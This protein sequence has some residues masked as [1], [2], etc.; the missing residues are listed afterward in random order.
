M[1]AN[2]TTLLRQLHRL[3]SPLPTAP[4]GDAILL[5]RF[6]RRRDEEAFAALVRRHGPMVLRVCRR[7]L[8]DADAAAD[9]CQAV[10]CVLA[11][12][13]AAIHSPE[14]LP[15]WLHGVAC[16]VARKARAADARRRGREAPTAELDPP[17]PH[18]DPLA[19]LSARDLL[20]T[21]D[22]EV[23]RLPEAHRLPVILCCLEGHTR[24]EAARLLGWSPGAVKGRLERGRARL[25]ARLVRRGLAL[26]A[27]L[28]AVEVARGAATL[29]PRLVCSAV[30][31]G[32]AF[33]ARNGGVSEQVALLAEAGLPAIGLARGKWV[34]A[35]LLA[36]SAVAAGAGM[37]AHQ[38]LA[39]K[40]P[41]LAAEG[42]AEPETAPAART[43]RYGDP[44]PPGALARLG[45]VRFRHPGQI[46]AFALSPDGKTVATGGYPGEVRLWE[47]ATGKPTGSLRLQDGHVLAL[48]FTPDGSA[49]AAVGSVSAD[50]N[51]AG[52]TVLFDLGT[53][54]PR[55]TLEHRHWARCLAFS[56]DGTTL[57]VGCDR[58]E[59]GTW[60]VASG[61]ERP[62]LPGEFGPGFA[63]VAFSPDGRLLA[64]GGYDKA[65]RLWDWRAGHEVG[66]LDAGS[67]VRSL[68]FASGGKT[69]LA[70]Q[71][72]PHFVQLWDVASR[73]VLRE[74][75]GHKGWTGGLLPG[76]SYAVALA[77][78]G[79]T[80]ASGGDDATVLL[81]DAGTAE[82][83]GRHQDQAG[84]VNGVAF[85]PDGKTLLTGGTIGR[86]RLFDVAG[87]KE[88]P[89]FDE[90]TGGLADMALSPD[91]KLLAT[92]SADR[93]ICLWDL[94]A[95]RTVRVLRGHRDGVYSVL[96]SPD[97]RSLVSGGGDGTVRV[98]DVA[99]GEQRQLTDAH[100]WYSRAAFA[101]D[102]KL[103]ASAG[104]DSKV[105]LWEPT[106]GREL[107]QL[108]GHMGY[109]V[110]LDISSDGKWLA[111]T[112][113]SYSGNDRS[114][115]DKTIRV[116]DEAKRTE[117][118]QITRNHFYSGP[119]RFTPDA[120]T[121][122]YADD[123]TLHFVELAA[124]REL[125]PSPYTGVADFTFTAGG[126]WLVT[127]GTDRTVR[128]RELASGLEMH[129]ITPGDCVVS[130]G[131]VAPAQ[132]TLLTLNQD[133]TVLVWDLA[134]P[135][136][137]REEAGSFDADRVW[138]DLESAD[139]PTV[140]RATWAL[141]SEPRRAVAELQHRLPDSLREATAHGQR[142]RALIAD[143]D[144]DSFERRQAATHE[145]AEIVTEAGPA[146]R[147]ALAGRPSAEA[148][149]RLEELLSKAGD[150]RSGEALRCL[151][152][153]TVLERIST[154]EARLL[155]ETAF[156][157]PEDDWLSREAKEALERGAARAGALPASR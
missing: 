41:P 99:T 78:D 95:G 44:L 138:A 154:P 17:D 115:E 43:D 55:L 75:N 31:A 156:K 11:R 60:D 127:V 71:D 54:K 102:G 28:A 106:S 134:P 141:A 22:E 122:V 61:K 135:G 105:R 58:D 5:D 155:L 90:H 128:L 98:W 3:V 14:A 80:V 34:L 56:P 52:R 18:P 83:C 146:L 113:E 30:Q 103:I 119:L 97:G 136:W 40:S 88:R 121:F 66:R 132:R 13:A 8:A 111:T 19:E 9:A 70:G 89:L 107:G 126:R 62:R 145:L 73:K 45:T 133:G 27:A 144:S 20:A 114:H 118:L 152:A 15:A 82:P 117:Y 35:L 24:E 91:G 49:L 109:L 6:V 50:H 51:A 142:I 65:I 42:G 29:P 77:P 1:P 59:F 92:A 26:P 116:W 64:A 81:W 153:L 124:G 67:I 68:A 25:H 96:F 85:T 110:G 33:A 104:A 38:A 157:G 130:K 63:S 21:V 100:D 69:L 37:L 150:L 7:V 39:G 74:F 48:R 125:R 108:T 151:R 16:R 140:Y 123:G 12:R 149:K 57:A 84:S 86:V 36:A 72:G 147:L 120:R 101:A 23:Q 93:T 76:S 53:G 131:M 112:G 46:L 139:G 32:L 94:A 4:D 2:P 87:G 47:S 129:R 148:R 137:G 79:R 143:L 10:F